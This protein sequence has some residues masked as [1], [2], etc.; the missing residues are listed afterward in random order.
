MASEVPE[1]VRWAVEQLEPRP[2]ERVLDIGS[3]TG[4]SV[5]VLVDLLVDPLRGQDAA[6]PAPPVVVAID[7]SAKAV[8]RIRR[9]VPQSVAAGT[10]D[11]RVCDVAGL[12]TAVGPL[13]AAI[14]VNVNVFWTSDAAPELATLAR[15]LA[16]GGRLLL[17]Y[18]D[19]P[20]PGM[21]R[22]HL[23][24]VGASVGASPWFEVTRRLDGD[25]GSA[26]V[27]V[28]RARPSS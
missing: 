9:R 26:L 16:P 24:R 7:R 14:A 6:A 10:V 5:E 4:A 20:A 25:H 12:D 3:G 28:T 21:D 19:G 23:D 13:D 1:R 22:G 17:A 2:G 18:G 27:A 15:V 8:E 11:L